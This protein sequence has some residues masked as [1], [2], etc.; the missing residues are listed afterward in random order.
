MFW[1]EH[2]RSSA[3]ESLKHQNIKMCSHHFEE[4][5]QKEIDDVIGRERSPCVEDRKSLP[6][7]NA[8]IHEVMR[9]LDLV[10]VTARYTMQDVTLRSFRILKVPNVHL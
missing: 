9:T 4:Q 3:S 10:P 2:Q 7:T 8:F 1:V 6:F 5:I